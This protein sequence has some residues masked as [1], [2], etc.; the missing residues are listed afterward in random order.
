MLEVTNMRVALAFLLVALGLGFGCSAAGK[1]TPTSGGGNECPVCGANQLCHLNASGVSEC[2]CEAGFDGCPLDEGG[3]AC[4]DEMTDVANC[5]SC[6]HRCPGSLQACSSGICGCVAVSTV[7]HCTQPD[8]G[9]DCVDLVKDPYHCGCG[10][11]CGLQY[12][13]ESLPD[14]TGVCRCLDGGVCSDAGP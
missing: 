6:G 13:C 2:V 10:F 4:V 3:L 1:A 12:E 11:P 8:G 5:G 9:L 7:V 14:G